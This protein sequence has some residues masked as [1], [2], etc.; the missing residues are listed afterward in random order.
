M[1]S[2]ARLACICQSDANFSTVEAHRGAMLRRIAE[3][4]P[5]KPD[6]IC[7]PEAFTS[8]GVPGPASRSAET[9]PGPTTD[10]LGAVARSSRCYVLCPIHTRDGDAIR[11]SAIVI[12][13]DGGIVGAYHKH[14]PVT[15]SADYTVFEDGIAPGSDIPVFDLDFGRVGV[16]ICFD[17]GFPENWQALAD[18]GAKLVIWTSAYDGGFP[19]QAY[20]YLHHYWVATSTR[21]QRSRIVDPCGEVVAETTPAKPSLSRSV[22]LDYVVSHLDWNGAIPDKIAAKH[23]DRVSVR[24][25]VPGSSHFIVEPLVPDVRVADLQKE[26][27]FEATALYHERHRRAYRRLRGG[28]RPEPQQALHGMRPQ[29]GK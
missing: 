28:K 18:K 8:V 26:F 20:A 24:Q 10:A 13:R 14:C 22:N 25:W 6:L 17:L 11:N 21:S 3:V 27:G 1:S 15:T 16:Q 2:I 12:G 7:L 9:V 29:W 23:G 5:D 4:L 19:L